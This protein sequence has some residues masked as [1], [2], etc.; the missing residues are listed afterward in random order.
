MTQLAWYPHTPAEWRRLAGALSFEEAGALQF[1]CDVAWD[2]PIP[3]TLADTPAAW[4]RLLGARWKKLVAVVRQHFTPCDEHPGRL[5]CAWLFDRYQTQL[6]KYEKR[7]VAGHTGGV[8]PGAK[9]G[10]KPKQPA[11]HSGS[12]GNSNANSNAIGNARSNAIAEERRGFTPG[13]DGPGGETPGGDAVAA[14][15]L[16]DGRA[17]SAPPLTAHDDQP[18]PHGSSPAAPDAVADALAWLGAQPDA[19]EREAA[20]TEHA[21]QFA[22]D[23][24]A[25]WIRRAAY[26]AALVEVHRAALRAPG[27]HGVARTGGEREPVSA[28][29]FERRRAAGKAMLGLSPP[30]LA[31]AP[32]GAA[33]VLVGAAPNTTP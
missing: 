20:I 18:L 15:A 13:P 4:E 26:E 25:E 27:A 16:P 1:A 23:G 7:A 24:A 33:P 12:N 5:R 21:A 28:E 31:D 19:A 9:R 29:E 2:D 10:R 30:D 22:G 11:K 3:C 8:A 6:A 14:L 17:A 32:P